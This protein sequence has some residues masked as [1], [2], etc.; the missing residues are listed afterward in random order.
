MMRLAS[1][2]H[3][4][5][6]IHP[7]PGSFFHAT[8]LRKINRFDFVRSNSFSRQQQAGSRP[9]AAYL[10]PPVASYHKSVKTREVSFA[11][12]GG[13]ACGSLLRPWLPVQ[14]LQTFART[15]SGFST[16]SLS[17]PCQGITLIALIFGQYAAHSGIDGR[18]NAGGPVSPC[19]LRHG[20]RI[21]RQSSAVQPQ[22]QPGAMPIPMRRGKAAG[23]GQEARASSSV[24]ETLLSF[25]TILHQR[26]NTLGMFAG[27]NSK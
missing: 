7:R 13:P 24:S 12:S 23:H 14:L 3:I 4:P 9:A 10:P 5:A 2:S 15:A 25:R 21:D 19:A 17:S 8:S 27:T 11:R 22:R 18:Q 20:R 26:Q 1:L 16:A 6:E